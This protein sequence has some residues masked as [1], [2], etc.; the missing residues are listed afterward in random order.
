M[1][2]LWAGGSVFGVTEIPFWQYAASTFVGIMPGCLLYL[3][4]GAARHALSGGGGGK[5]GAAQWSLFVAGL[6]ATLAVTV[7]VGRKAK[8]MLE[9]SGATAKS[10]DR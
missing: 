3:Y 4:I 6:I 7:I 8:R 9:D 1:R 10:H 5:W 2:L